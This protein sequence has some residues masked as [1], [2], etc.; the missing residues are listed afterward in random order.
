MKL[1]VNQ[2][3][4][5]NTCI[6]SASE[7]LHLRTSPVCPQMQRRAS[8]RLHGGHLRWVFSQ[9]HAKQASAEMKGFPVQQP[10]H[11]LFPS[12]PGIPKGVSAQ[13]HHA[14]PNQQHKQ[15]ARIQSL[16]SS[17]TV[18]LQPICRKFSPSWNSWHCYRSCG[19][20]QTTFLNLSL[21]QRRSEFLGSS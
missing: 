6:L 10:A 15:E 1:S 17:K 12:S 16:H 18:R 11:Q 21:C 7:S 20:D 13:W 9:N 14:S 2:M 4:A 19:H 5:A 8:S 3:N